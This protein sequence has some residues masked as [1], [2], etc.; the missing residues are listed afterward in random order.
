[1]LRG[2]E[3]NKKEIFEQIEMENYD[4][5]DDY[6]EIV[7]EFGYLTLF[8]ECF[9]LAPVFVLIVNSIELRSD[10]FKLATVYKRPNYIRKR[11]IGIWNLIIQVI[12]TLSVFTNLLFTITYSEETLLKSYISKADEGLGKNQLLNFFVLEHL[13]LLVIIA[14]RLGISTSEGWVKLFLARRDYKSKA[15]KWKGLFSQ[16]TL[17]K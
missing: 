5:F 8:A 17:N 13:V 6:L 9:P 14:I 2:K 1:M 4:T 7:L 15:N 11:N 10:I 3:V 16:N 12:S